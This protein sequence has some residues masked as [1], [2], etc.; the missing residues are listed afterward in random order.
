MSVR[1]TRIDPLAGIPDSHKPGV[2]SIEKFADWGAAFDSLR[3]RGIPLTAD[4]EEE[5]RS[6]ADTQ[7]PWNELINAGMSAYSCR[8]QYDVREV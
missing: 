2:L 6:H 5:F 4:H 7:F 1:I 8:V 3:A